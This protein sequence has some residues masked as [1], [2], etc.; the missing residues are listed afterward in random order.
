MNTFLEIIKA[1][2]ISP[3]SP[4]KWN[5]GYRIHTKRDIYTWERDRDT[6]ID[7]RDL[8]HVIKETGESTVH[9]VV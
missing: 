8:V 1:W 9:R 5:P 3:S 4:E 7:F 6:E 2:Y